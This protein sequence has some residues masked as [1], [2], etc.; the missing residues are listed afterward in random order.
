M[1]RSPRPKSSVRAALMALCMTVLISGALGVRL[2]QCDDVKAALYSGD[3]LVCAGFL[4]CSLFIVHGRRRPCHACC[5]RGRACR[6]AHYRV[7]T[8]EYQLLGV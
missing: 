4:R 7:G 5:R 8:E 2:G 3:G 6:E 1:D